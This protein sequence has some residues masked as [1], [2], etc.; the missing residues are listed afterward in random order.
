MTNAGG[1]ASP[2]G[3]TLGDRMASRMPVLVMMLCPLLLLSACGGEMSLTEYVDRLNAL[4]AEASARAERLRSSGESADLTPQDLATGLELSREIRETVQ[5]A[6]D[7]IDPPSQVEDL[8]DR[9][10]DWHARFMDVEAALARRASGVEDTDAGWSDLS[11]SREMAD[12]RVALADGKQLC[13]GFQAEL[14][15]TSAR[16]AF[17]DVPWLPGEMSEVVEA[18]VGC[19]WFPD[20]PQSV[21]QWPPPADP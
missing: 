15:A 12:Y 2:S 9:V 21:F 3:R 16:G 13:D 10:F 11:D 17:E 4:E 19:E 14:D 6:A 8:H 1:A 18:V 7:D 5:D 20:D